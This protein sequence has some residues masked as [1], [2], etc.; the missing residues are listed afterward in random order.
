L[1]AVIAADARW[2]LNSYGYSPHPLSY[3]I[4]TI[5]QIITS[6]PSPNGNSHKPFIISITSSDPRELDIMLNMIQ[7]LRMSLGEAKH[8]IAI[9][10]N[11][12]CPN[13][14][15]APPPAYEPALLVPLIAIFSKH[16]EADPSLTLGL[17]L[18][19][20][21]FKDQYIKM[22]AVLELP[23]IAGR[24]PIAF[25]S[26]TNTLG[27][28]LFFGN[29]GS[30]FQRPSEN[31]DQPSLDHIN[32]LEES[33]EPEFALPTPLGGLAGQAL[34]PLALGNVF[35]FSTALKASSNLGLKEIRIIGIGGV[36]DA[37]GAKRMHAAG[38]E[39]VGLATA[40]GTH[41][42]EVFEKIRKEM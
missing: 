10:F 39:V 22:L 3:Y 9:E 19:P 26:C 13:I 32:K 31:P 41:G 14:L 2:S 21:V 42:V 5:S 28:S 33:T 12:S 15:Y 4:K 7:E 40:L 8:R 11:A 16:F 18:P 36:H 34:H 24:C 38:A 20:Y 27:S 37:R 35:S 30:D 6:N 29:P 17:K 25:L 23:L 1:Q